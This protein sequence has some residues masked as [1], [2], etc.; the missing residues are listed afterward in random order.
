MLHPVLN[1]LFILET[2]WLS[3]F[4]AISTA[5]KVHLSTSTPSPKH[6]A[7]I[8]Q[9]LNDAA[10]ALHRVLHEAGIKHDIFGGFAIGSL[11]GPRE[12]QGHRL[13]CFRI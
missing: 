13:H 6:P 1:D 8:Q 11:G 7:M 4:L 2:T 10:I 3:F 12:K 5:L 9:L